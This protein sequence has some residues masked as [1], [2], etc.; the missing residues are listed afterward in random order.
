MPDDPVWGP[1]LGAYIDVP[2][3][4]QLMW[5]EFEYRDMPGTAVWPDDATRGIPT[6]YGYAFS[7]LAQAESNLN[8]QA[9]VEKNMQRSTEWLDLA[10]R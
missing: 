1:I 6:Y 4:R 10:G 5:N 7:A 9:E 2:R 8:N 3:T